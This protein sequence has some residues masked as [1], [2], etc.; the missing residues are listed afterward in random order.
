M[1]V[2]SPT[3]EPLA[4][5]PFAD[6]GRSIGR[7]VGFAPA[8]TTADAGWKNLAL[9]AWHGQ[10]DVARFE[11][12][13]E[14]VIVYHAGGAQSVPARVNRHSVHRTHPGRVTIIPP[15]T[16]VVWEI[17][18]EV[19]SRSVHLSSQF[20]RSANGERDRAAD[21]RFCCGVE[22]RLIP[23]V[24]GTL[25]REALAPSQ[26]GSLYADSVADTLALHLVNLNR[27][28]DERPDQK[29][30]LSP[31]LLRRSVDRLEASIGRGVSL[32][33][34]ADEVQLNRTYFADAFRRATGLAPHRYL[35]QL[36]VERAR[37]LLHRTA[38]PI[39]A[40]ALQCGF[41]SQAHLTTSFKA[42]C[43]VTPKRFREQC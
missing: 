21:L 16:R 1:K 31:K 4:R 36:R 10:C 43:G 13:E 11:P 33:E 12:F 24:I 27:I 29:G 30:A 35:T 15:D 5:A 9:F 14:P 32:Q 8:I 20:L 39:S 42:V 23:A 22:D 2:A 18:G 38:L 6:S 3:A 26:T 41:S 19:Y 17:R 40:I 37:S 34:L 28:L 7:A 25:E